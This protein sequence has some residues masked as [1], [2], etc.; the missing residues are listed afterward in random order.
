MSVTKLHLSEKHK[1]ALTDRSDQHHGQYQRVTNF[2]QLGGDGDDGGHAD[3][4]RRAA[5]NDPLY[6]A[7]SPKGNSAL[8]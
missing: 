3:A 2:Q 1:I 5:L 7:S 8:L 6:L 4:D